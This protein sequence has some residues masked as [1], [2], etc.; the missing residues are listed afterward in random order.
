M[1]GQ[2]P[3]LLLKINFSII[4]P[5][6]VLLTRLA[7]TTVTPRFSQFSLAPPQ[8]QWVIFFWKIYDKNK[9]FPGYSSGW[10]CHFPSSL[11]CGGGHFPT[12]VLSQELHVWVHGPHTRKVSRIKLSRNMQEFLLIVSPQIRGQGGGF[13]SRWR[14]P[15][16]HDDASR[17]RRQVFRGLD[18]E[19]AGTRQ[20]DKRIS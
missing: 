2:S 16:L 7:T 12:S 9:D 11:V 1:S 18:R 17:S 19:A 14:H 20:G 10:F 5:T 8:N 3:H 6:F 15:A 13:L 4:S